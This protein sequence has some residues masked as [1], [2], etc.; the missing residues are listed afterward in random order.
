MR[1]APFLV[2]SLGALLSF[3][4]AAEDRVCLYPPNTFPCRGRPSGRGSCKPPGSRPLPEPFKH[5]GPCPGGSSELNKIGPKADQEERKCRKRYPCRD[6][7]GCGTRPKAKSF[8]W[9]GPCPRGYQEDIKGSSLRRPRVCKKLR[10]QGGAKKCTIARKSNCRSNESELD[11]KDNR[12]KTL[13][14]CKMNKCRRRCR[15][16]A[17]GFCPPNTKELRRKGSAGR[18]SGNDYS[19]DDYGAEDYGA[20]DFKA[21][22]FKTDDYE[23]D[24]YEADDFEAYEYESD[25]YEADEYQAD[26]YEAYDYNRK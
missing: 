16:K 9:K 4:K 12:K 2:F 5:D 10:C 23:A 26:D 8:D 13:R 14:S 24:E 11:P 19:A 17:R 1:S 15:V 6:R 3:S 25:D 22:D 21:D 18:S 7:G 20:D